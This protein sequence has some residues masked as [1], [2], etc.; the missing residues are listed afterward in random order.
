M[1]K[2]IDDYTIAA[3]GQEKKSSGIPSRLSVFSPAPKEKTT[4]TTPKKPWWEVAAD[5]LRRHKEANKKKKKY[6]I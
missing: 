1:R 6:I 5:S 3:D 2:V 4:T